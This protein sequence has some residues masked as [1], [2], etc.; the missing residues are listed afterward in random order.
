VQERLLWRMAL[1]LDNRLIKL[2]DATGDIL[3]LDRSVVEK[4]YYVTKVIHALSNLEDEYFAWYLLVE[5]V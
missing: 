3:E 5:P 2:V 1:M 4:D